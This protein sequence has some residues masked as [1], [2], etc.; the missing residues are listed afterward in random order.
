MV[1]C[2]QSRSLL[3]GL[4]VSSMVTGRRFLRCC[5]WRR[6]LWWSAMCMRRWQPVHRQVLLV[7]GQ[8]AHFLATRI[9]GVV[10]VSNNEIRNISAAHRAG[11]LCLR[12]LP[13]GR[14]AAKRGRVLHRNPRRRLA[15]FAGI[16]RVLPE[17]RR[18][19]ARAE[20]P[21]MDATLVGGI[22]RRFAD[23]Q[24]ARPAFRLTQPP[25]RGSSV[26]PCH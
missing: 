6:W 9:H 24:N 3:R 19:A 17:L 8:A 23:G 4:F 25:I 5:A 2:W 21:D 20:A 10:T 16:G 15:V 12:G 11:R 26:M 18:G 22:A 7:P 14:G 1:P 13:E